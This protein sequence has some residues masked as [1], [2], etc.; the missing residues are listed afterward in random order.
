[1][2]DRAP[3]PSRCCATGPSL[4]R[5]GR[6]LDGQPVIIG[7]GLAGLMTALHL[8]PRPV[9]VLTKASLGAE[10]A[11][12]WAQG[13][14]AAALGADDD[15]SLH[16][17]DTLASGDGLSDRAAVERIICA[18]AQVIDDL[19]RHGVA[20]DRDAAG[21]LTFGL[22]AAHSRRRIVHA[23]GGDGAGRAILRALVWAAR[24]SP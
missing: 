1:M 9:V 20:F 5:E 10:A 18:G 11:S 3:S 15:T 7:A 8:A 16:V 23:G 21:A 19:V 14:V 24:R 6:G 12:G 2:L 22:E 13:G 4:S 17:A